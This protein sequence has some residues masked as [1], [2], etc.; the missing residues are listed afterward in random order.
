MNQNVTM[1]DDWKVITKKLFKLCNDIFDLVENNNETSFEK[2]CFEKI[3]DT[4]KVIEEKEITWESKAEI[5]WDVLDEI[6]IDFDMFKPDESSIVNKIR[7][8]CKRRYDFAHLVDG[9]IFELQP[10]WKDHI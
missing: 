3:V 4:N 5:L 9:Y 10:N 6:E 2:S 1:P 8:C 7:E